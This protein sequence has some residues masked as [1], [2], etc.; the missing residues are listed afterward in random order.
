MSESNLQRARPLKT[1][2]VPRAVGMFLLAG[3]LVFSAF[4]ALLAWAQHQVATAEAIRDA[5]TLTN[6]EASDVIGPLLSDAAL[7]PGPAQDALD[8]AVRKRVLGTWIVRLKIWD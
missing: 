7:R 4:A 3:L 2:S 1:V 8:G 5:R 6:L